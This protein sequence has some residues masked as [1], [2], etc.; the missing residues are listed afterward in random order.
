MNADNIIKICLPIFIGL[1][2]R[3]AISLHSY[4]GQ[5]KPPMYGDYEAQRH[6]ME[7]TFNLPPT[8]WY[9]NTT[10]NDLNYWGLDYPPL[11]AYHS[12]LMGAL[13]SL[14]NNEWVQLYKS[15]GFESKEHKL[16]MRY[17]VFIADL[18]IFIPFVIV[19][20]YS[21]LPRIVN[22]DVN[23]LKQI[24][25]FYSACLMLTYP[26]IILI[27]HGHFQYNCISL[28]LYLASVNCLLLQWDIF[29][30][31]LFCLALC[32]KQMELYHSL[33]IFFYLLSVCLHKSTLRDGVI[34]FIKLGLTVLLTISL[35]FTPFLLTT[36]DANSV[37]QVIKRL[38]P[39]DRGIYEDKVSNFWCAT[40]PLVKWRSLFPPASSA[41][42][43]PS[44]SPSYELVL[45][46]IL[47]V[48]IT[49]LPC[50]LIL[51]KKSTNQQKKLL[52][53]LVICSLGF[54]LFSFQVHEKSIL[55]VTI[56]VLCLLPIYP[57]SS[58][59]FSLCSVLSMWP[60]LK[61]DELKLASLSLVC[62]YCILGCFIVF[63]NNHSNNNK[64]NSDNTNHGKHNTDKTLQK[65][66]SSDSIISSKMSSVFAYCVILLGYSILIVGDMFITPPQAYPDL[67]PLL[68]SMY[69]FALFFLFLLYWQWKV[70][71]D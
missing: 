24:S 63:R 49:C 66:N 32:Y 3:S 69:S 40:S 4:S 56:P 42:S 50:C 48:S 1:T 47:L 55:L 59:L 15:R 70:I 36:N 9:T 45:I 33:P 12:W 38:F 30:S 68:F 51:L 28:G 10:Q 13:A 52:I 39:L 14:I 27:D 58:F 60:L 19:Y 71:F 46:S 5:G 8:E 62:I 26:G 44:S 34:H 25:G 11:T 35:V 43:S 16:F 31:I 17:T 21:V 61:K 57:A 53:S 54:Y 37:Y 20:F 2:V 22:T 29:A 23:R 18:L 67:F 41:L 64:N 6:W 7:I 65:T